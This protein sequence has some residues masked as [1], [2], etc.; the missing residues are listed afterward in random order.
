MKKTLLP[1]LIFFCCICNAQSDLF[2]PDGKPFRNWEDSTRYS[3]TYFVSQGHP[4]ASDENPGT[5][6]RPF[7]TIGHAANHLQPGEKVIIQSGTYRETVSPANGGNNARE[8]ISYEAAPGAKVIVTGADILDSEWDVSKAPNDLPFSFKLWQTEL[9]ETIFK[10]ENNPF[11]IPNA[12]DEEID[13]MPW[14]VKWKGQIPYTLPRGMVFQND[15]RLVQMSSYADLVKVP[16]S[17]WVAG[18][19]KTIH[20]H[21]FDDANPNNE[22]IEVTAR[23][24]LF[25]PEKVGTS[26]IHLKGIHF[27]KAGNGFP[28]VGVGAVYVNGGDHWI[29]EENIVRQ[30]NSVGIEIGARVTEKSASS[31]AENQRVKNHP[32]GFIVRNNK[33]FECGTGGIQGHTNLNTMVSDN[34]IFNIGWQDVERYWECAAIKLLR[35]VNN[36]VCDNEIHD[37]QGACAI[38]LDWDI[39][40]S[41]ISRNVI[42]D[43]APN[44]NGAV[45]VEASQVPNLIDNNFLWDVGSIGVALYDSDSTTVT[46]NFFGHAKQAV[47]SRVNT[48]RSLNG[49]PLTSKNNRIVNNIFYHVE[50]E[51]VIEDKDNFS[52]YNFFVSKDSNKLAK[53]KKKEWDESSMQIPFRAVF[54]KNKLEILMQTVEAFPFMNQDIPVETDFFETHRNKQV[55]GPFGFSFKGEITLKLK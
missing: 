31:E 38:W 49:R 14:A 33:V 5:I 52:D 45:F 4:E 50:N 19:G 11:A 15:Q 44:A 28:R 3:K 53:W 20:I 51:S 16:G 32:G 36:I 22:K 43:I 55:A 21:P 47:S 35:D 9:P 48:N 18:D 34:H 26:Y 39:R 24:Q 13:L 1:V 10:D 29:I 23:Q 8:M 2:L 37:I 54:N 30:C 25:K 46:N 17:Y 41:R 27:E 12:S 42:Y 7:K 6:N 40:N